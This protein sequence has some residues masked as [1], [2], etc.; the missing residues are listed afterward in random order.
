M[1]ENCTFF[2]ADE[3]FRAILQPIL[4][5]PIQQINTVST[6]WTNVVL[7][8]TTLDGTTYVARFPRNEFFAKQIRKDVIT[9]QFLQ[10]RIKLPVPQMQLHQ[11]QQ[12]CF[13]LHIRL[14]GTALT[15]CLSLLNPAQQQQTATGIAEF[16]WNLHRIPVAQLPIELR[17]YESDFLTELLGVTGDD[18]DHSYLQYMA[19]AEQQESVFIHGDLNIGNVLLDEQYNISG[20]LD[21]AF[22][23]ISDRHVDLSI[24]SSRVSAEFLTM[25][26]QAYEQYSHLTLDRQKIAYYGELRRYTEQ[27]YIAYLRHNNP[28]VEVPEA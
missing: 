5:Q 16:L 6:G 22:A 18:F 12:R 20:F 19:T 10:Q 25:I 24:I 23:G 8:V 11:Y 1:I 27:R 4:P 14:P 7:E 15:T 9:N 26:L 2:R 17:G 28:E 3:D 21:F 13:S